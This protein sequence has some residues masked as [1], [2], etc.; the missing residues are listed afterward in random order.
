MLLKLPH[1]A[2]SQRVSS[3]FSFLNQSFTGFVQV[4]VR[5]PITIAT[6][7]LF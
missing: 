6:A 1:A 2:K 7:L 5:R 3:H 4:N